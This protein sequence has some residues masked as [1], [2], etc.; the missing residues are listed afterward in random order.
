[1]GKY[2]VTQKEW[3][4]VMGTTVH[5]QRDNVG[6]IWP[7][8]GEGDDYPIYYISWFDAIEYCNKLSQLE[9]LTPVYSGTRD[10]VIFDRDANGYRLPTE[11]EWEYAAKGGNGS[12]GNYTY[13]GSNIADEVAWHTGLPTTRLPFHCRTSPLP[14]IRF[15]WWNPAHSSSI[16]AISL[17]MC[18]F[19]L[20]RDTPE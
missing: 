14:S 6:K 17:D 12:P 2:P 7:I 11:A 13:S 5:Q 9:G 18:L 20:R 8:R 1:M 10:N 15:T 19:N 16:S 3:H 4:E